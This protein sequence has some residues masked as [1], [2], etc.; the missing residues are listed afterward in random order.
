MNRCD[1]E[2]RL[3][4]YLLGDL[5]EREEAE[6]S[7]HL[8]G[9]AVCQA[10]ASE[11]TPVL[12]SL[13]DG[14]ARDGERQ[15]RLSPARR[16][17]LLRVPAAPADHKVIRWAARP[18]PWLAAAACLLLALVFS[19]VLIPSFMKSRSSSRAGAAFT[20][21]TMGRTVPER[22]PLQ[23]QGGMNAPADMDS[24]ISVA[25]GQRAPADGKDRLSL[26]GLGGGKAVRGEAEKAYEGWWREETVSKY[27]AAK[28]PVEPI[29]FEACV[30]QPAAEVVALSDQSPIETGMSVDRELGRDY[31]KLPSGSGTEV[32]GTLKSRLVMKGLYASRTAGGREAALKEYGDKSESAT[33]A[34]QPADVGKSVAYAPPP[35]KPA[36]VASSAAA[37]HEHEVAE[38]SREI[39]KSLED[40]SGR[41]G[42]LQPLLRNLETTTVAVNG[43][44]TPVGGS[45]SPEESARNLAP[46][47][48]T[49]FWSDHVVDATASRAPDKAGE[50]STPPSGASAAIVHCYANAVQ[51][52]DKQLSDDKRASDADGDGRSSGVA[53]KED[54]PPP[55]I[56]IPPATEAPP[57]DLP[58]SACDTLFV[59]TNLVAFTA[60][61]SQPVEAA[62]ARPARVRAQSFNPFV[63]T[64]DDHF[65]TFSIDVNTAS[66]TLTR[67]AIRAGALPEAETVRTEEIVNAFDFCDTAPDYAT[68]RVYVEGAPSAFGEPGLT[69][70]RIGVKGRRLGREEQ[71]PAMLTFL[72][73]TSGSMAQ[74]NRIGRARTALRL[75]LDQLAPRD[76]I[77]IVSFDDKARL[78]LGPTAATEKKAILKAFDQLQCNGSTNLEDGMRRA[79]QQAATA[80]LPGGENR[81]ILISDGVANLG[82]DNAQDILQQVEAFRKQGVTCS[83]FGVGEGSYNDAMLE[84]LANKGQGVYRF[85]DTDEEVKRVFVDDLA[86]TLN[87]IATDVKI[88]VEW[89]AD[90]VRRFRQ[91]GYER[92][93]LRAE[94]FRDDTVEAGE[95]GSGQSVTAMYELDLSPAARSVPL[96]T[97]RV[98]FRR[99]DT[100][101]IE[102]IEQV[103][104]PDRIAASLADTR[105][106]FRLA[107][108]ASAFAELLR[109]SP[110][111]TR[112]LAAAARLLR[113]VSQEL[114]L[115]ARVRELLALVEAAEALSR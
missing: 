48:R 35:A 91:L 67:Q 31:R 46:G 79:Y 72:V 110:Y 114:A 99:M 34:R 41:A 51:D 43:K 54:A 12:Q 58:S 65:S 75:L 25:A 102:E 5:S 16:R 64:S 52:A 1:Q 11:L 8:A 23:L 3:T 6:Y 101:T 9:C 66:Y 84:A 42:E 92:R 113:P 26:D 49:W 7:R 47:N 68:F 70:L 18:R 107:M 98:R 20:L 96:G 76:R 86:A 24:G 74:P 77:Q 19:A 59:T 105:P 15:P 29:T 111:V 112:D 21:G 62:A 93:A 53:K 39:A 10:S 30:S 83:V 82:S 50:R 13:A 28:G 115:D 4:P 73:D 37:K 109:G 33:Y 69:L 90:A 2:Q 108:G 56:N 100:G 71:R 36:P 88:Q 17:Q 61:A 80:F 95:V 63:L 27:K 94:Q 57:A 44:V 55:R 87:N 104:T 103:I 89:S 45:K 60:V 85:L 22:D 106:Q 32:N 38:R 81:V 14:L 97:V 78:V 40:V